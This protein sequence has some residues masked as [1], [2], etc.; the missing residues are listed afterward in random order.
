M[1]T[2]RTIK[3]WFLPILPQNALYDA[4]LLCI[5]SYDIESMTANDDGSYSFGDIDL[6]IEWLDDEAYAEIQLSVGYEV[7]KGACII[8]RNYVDHRIIISHEI[9]GTHHVI[10]SNI[11]PESILL[12]NYRKQFDDLADKIVNVVRGI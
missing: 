6:K 9:L 4:I 11:T 8:L 3:T 12:K 1:L 2:F 7:G 10:E 5:E